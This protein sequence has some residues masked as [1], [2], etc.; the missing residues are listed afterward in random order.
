[1]SYSLVKVNAIV[2]PAKYFKIALIG[3]VASKRFEIRW[4]LNGNRS[5]IG[6]PG[7]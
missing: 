7:L 1:M 2:C 6:I 3:A 4:D 5:N